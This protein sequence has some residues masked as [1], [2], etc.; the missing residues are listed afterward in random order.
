MT[1]LM[2]AALP[3]SAA[4]HEQ[5]SIEAA[6]D[7]RPAGLTDADLARITAAIGAARTESTRTVYAHTWTQWER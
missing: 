6:T 3:A 7:L 5:P 1:T 4:A 2:S